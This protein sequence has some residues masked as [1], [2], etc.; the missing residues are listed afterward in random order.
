VKVRL[1]PLI[2]EHY[3]PMLVD[4]AFLIVCL[5]GW[6][7][8][9]GGADGPGSACAIVSLVVLF[10]ITQVTLLVAV[11]FDDDAI[12]IIR[13]W[14][15]RRVPWSQVAGLVYTAMPGTYGFRAPGARSYH[16]YR[17][18]LVLKDHQPPIGRF[19]TQT[20]LARFAGPVVMTVS[21]L[22]GYPPLDNRETR[23]AD[24]VYAELERHGFPRPRPVPLE[25][26][27]PQYTDDEVTRAVAIDLLRLH[28]VTVTHGPLDGDAS[29][30][31]LDTDLPE[32]AHGAGAVREIHREPTYAIYSFEDE[33][34]AAA[35]AAAARGVVPATWPV[36]TGAL[37]EPF[38][39]R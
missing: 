29:R 39:A 10:H 32:L 7:A 8:V 18:H 16:P 5:V 1:Y 25:F 14:R 26:R 35:F 2:A 24:K 34:P 3:F 6:A 28:P 33:P 12:T 15:R 31:L 9:T 20:E 37:P 36:T 38:R 30:R 21:G 4:V 19:R 23:C 11:R 17:L 22:G 27:Y 13:P